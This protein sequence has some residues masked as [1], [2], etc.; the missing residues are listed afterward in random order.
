MYGRDNET[1]NEANSWK[2]A[3]LRFETN[4]NEIWI[5]WTKYEFTKH[6]ADM[7]I[8]YTLILWSSIHN[9]RNP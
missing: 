5:L 2:Q 9:T 6:V 3:Q 8:D 1:K 4:Q 7:I